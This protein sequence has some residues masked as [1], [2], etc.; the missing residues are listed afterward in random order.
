MRATYG[1]TGESTG[2]ACHILL[3]ALLRML[4]Q[5]QKHNRLK[6]QQSSVRNINKKKE[7]TWKFQKPPASENEKV[8]DFSKIWSPNNVIDVGKDRLSIEYCLCPKFWIKL[9]I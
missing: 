6:I 8:F 2:G 5:V 3:F 4:I 1:L 7:I 9:Q